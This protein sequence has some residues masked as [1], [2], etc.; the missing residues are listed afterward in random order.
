MSSK[1]LGYTEAATAVLNADPLTDV[2]ISLGWRTVNGQR[3]PVL[4]I[5]SKSTVNYKAKATPLGTLFGNASDTH[6]AMLYR[7][8]LRGEELR[9]AQWCASCPPKG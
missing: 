3:L 1:T 8:G 2:R 5:S 6:F 7:L 9:S 4:R